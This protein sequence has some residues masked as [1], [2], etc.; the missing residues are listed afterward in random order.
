[1]GHLRDH[2]NFNMVTLMNKTTILAM[3]LASAYATPAPAETLRLSVETKSDTG[4]VRAAIYTSPDAFEKD[5]MLIGV[6]GP[7]KPGVTQLDVN[8]LEPGIYG[9][10][11]FQDMNGNEKLDMNLFG[12]PT[13]P[14]GFSNNP[15]IGFKAPEFAEF[16]F[17]FDGKPKEIRVTLNGE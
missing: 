16:Q 2:R 10:A 11:V 8:G 17:E 9:V 6:T 14:F 15:V 4:Y 12:A 7:A 13:E 1:M 3:I 5:D